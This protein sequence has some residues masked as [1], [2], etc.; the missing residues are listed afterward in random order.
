MTLNELSNASGLN[1]NGDYT[2]IKIANRNNIDKL[3]E[4]SVQSIFTKAKTARHCK[5]STLLILH[6][7]HL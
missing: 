5:T 4:I 3:K 6:N 7:L 2:W 1:E